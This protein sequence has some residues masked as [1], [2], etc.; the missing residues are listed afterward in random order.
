MRWKGLALKRWLS[1][2]LLDVFECFVVFGLRL[3]DFQQTAIPFVIFCHA[4]FLDKVKATHG[5]SLKGGTAPVL[6]PV[7]AQS[8]QVQVRKGRGV[9]SLV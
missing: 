1:A 9:L 6:P 4:H 7:L 2:Y 3:L 5:Q 8:E